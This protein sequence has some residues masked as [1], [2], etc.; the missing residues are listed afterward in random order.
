MDARQS[1]AIFTAKLVAC[2]TVYS[3]WRR[4]PAILI[5]AI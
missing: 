5:S 1:N 3:R 4:V 2:S